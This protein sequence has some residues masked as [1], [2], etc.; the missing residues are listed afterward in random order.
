V[1]KSLI[2]PLEGGNPDRYHRKRDYFQKFLLIRVK[3]FN[4][5]IAIECSLGNTTNEVT[6]KK[7]GMQM[8]YCKRRAP[9]VRATLQEGG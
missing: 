1:N 9:V 3:S 2:F 7:E 8:K 5:I 6:F 4:D